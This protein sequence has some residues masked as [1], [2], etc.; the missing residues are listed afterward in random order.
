MKAVARSLVLVALLQAPSYA[1]RLNI[2]AHGSRPRPAPLSTEQVRKLPLEELAAKSFGQLSDAVIAAI[3][4]G[5]LMGGMALSDLVFLTKP[6]GAGIG[7]L[8]RSTA[9][10]VHFGEE[11]GPGTKP[12]PLQTAATPRRAD[13]LMSS[14][15]FKVAGPLH[16][17]K[18]ID[19]QY[20]WDAACSSRADVRSFMITNIQDEDAF[21]PALVGIQNAIDQ[22]RAASGPNADLVHLPPAWGGDVHLIKL[23]NAA[24][25]RGV[26]EGS[27]IASLE[28]VFAPKG[29]DNGQGAKMIIRDVQWHWPAFNSPDYGVP[30][31]TT[32][33]V[34]IE[35][36]SVIYD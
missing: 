12:T 8:C 27:R 32:G 3:P 6:T 22:R 11:R 17:L 28:V 26:V 34:T 7:G 16:R 10:A 19:E 35:P 25:V 15:R 31:V 20:G 30:N 5:G 14:H 18:T 33:S 13:D 2:P 24:A 1:Q 4:Q 23:E 9:L 21:I 29:E 36:H